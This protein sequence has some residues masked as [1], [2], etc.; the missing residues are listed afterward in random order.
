MCFKITLS[1]AFPRVEPSFHAHLLMAPKSPCHTAPQRG[2]RNSPQQKPRGE[3]SHFHH[4]FAKGGYDNILLLVELCGLYQQLSSKEDS[5]CCVGLFSFVT[6]PPLP[7]CLGPSTP[8]TA[9]TANICATSM[10]PEGLSQLVTSSQR[11]ISPSDASPSA[12]FLPK[13]LRM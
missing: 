13:G 9:L 2:W 7:F 3:N 6:A 5:P 12:S 10:H 8:V 1:A 11:L 4:V